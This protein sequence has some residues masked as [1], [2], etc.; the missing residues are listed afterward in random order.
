MGDRLIAALEQRLGADLTRRRLAAEAD[1]E[2]RIAGKGRRFTLADNHAL[3][4]A[5][6]NGAVRLVGLHGLGRS[7]ATRI[8]VAENRIE[9]P[10]L[11]QAFEGYTILQVSDLHAD[12]SRA[13][14]AELEKL[15]A[16]VSAD[17]CVLTGDYRGEIYGPIDEAMAIMARI[18]AAIR[19]PMLGVLG[20]HD[21]IRMVPAIEA[22]G[23]R[24]LMNEAMTLERDGAAI[25]MAGIDDAH[26]YRTHDI[27]KTRAGIDAN[28]FSIL[29]SHTPEVYAEAG[30]AGFDVM[31]SGHT[32]GGQICLPN[33]RPLFAGLDR[34]PEL[35]SGHWRIGAMQ[36]YT[37][38][39]LGT[40]SWP[41]RIN[42]PAEIAVLRLRAVGG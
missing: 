37:N 12:I 2:A 25:V 36:G 5:I 23:V 24:L 42:C 8:V 6:V 20:N 1:I 32:H 14:M 31:L 18:C 7:N 22:M 10:R 26:F 38:R 39:G 41:L 33:G 34:N 16:G 28:A 11:P 35:A 15:V 30:S 17:L 27:G 4:S 21:S 9:S 29:L 3:G 19:A 40:A 13:A